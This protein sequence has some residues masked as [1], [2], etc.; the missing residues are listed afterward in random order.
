MGWI[1]ESWDDIPCEVIANSFKACGISKARDGSEDGMIVC[2][3]EG[4]NC[5]AAREVLTTRI[6]DGTPTVNV[7]SDSELEEEDMMSL[8]EFDDGNNSQDGSSDEDISASASELDTDSDRDS[9][10]SGNN[11]PGSYFRFYAGNVADFL[12]CF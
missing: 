5:A 12:L 4:R 2:M 9:L 7:A 3:R 8:A 10:H 1:V 11:S 6:K